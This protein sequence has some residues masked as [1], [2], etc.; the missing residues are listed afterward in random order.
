MGHTKMSDGA[1]AA[2][3]VRVCDRYDVIFV[4]E[5]RDQSNWTQTTLWGL[6]N[7]TDPQGWGFTQSAPIGR[8]SYKEEY[9]FYW[10]T[11]RA[12]LAGQWQAPD[13]RDVYEREPFGVQL[14]YWSTQQSRSQTAVLLG[15]HAKPTMAVEELEEMPNSVK[16]AAAA[17]P[18]AA[19]VIAMGDFNADCSYASAQDLNDLQIFK[20]SAGF[21]TL[22]PD[23]TD[24]T[25][26]TNTDCAYDRAVV[27]GGLTVQGARVYNFQS[28]LGLDFASAWDVSDHYPI[29]FQLL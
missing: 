5:T 4:M 14:E 10:R 8:T 6:L 28:G 22:I 15:L 1:V 27:Y 9:V 25:T 3:I 11:S 23:S 7:A 19:G 20:S 12:Q 18:S 24:T 26:S 17:F 2:N 16:A 29:E 21:T 13:P